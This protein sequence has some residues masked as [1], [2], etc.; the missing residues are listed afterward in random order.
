MSNIYIPTTSADQWS[1]LLAEPTKHWRT[2]YSARTLAYSWQEAD[3]FPKEVAACLGTSASLAG[4]KML[5]GL[6]EHQVALPGGGRPSQNDVWVLAKAGEH[7]LSVAVEGKVAEPFGPTLEEW[8][9]QPSD[10]KSKRLAFLQAELG[11]QERPPQSI[12]YQLLHR[13]AS[14]TIEARRLGAA[15]ALMLVHSFSQQHQW[16]EDFSAFAALFGVK[17]ELGVV[18]SAGQR[19]GVHLHLAWVCG[20]PAYLSK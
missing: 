1:A 18:H 10:G 16:F 15:H 2:G 11:L 19:A 17:P 14:A 20:D 12:R 13:T 9:E 7:L 5:L 8:L 4:A 6:P 3:G